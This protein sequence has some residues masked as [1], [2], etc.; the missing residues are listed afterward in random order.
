MDWGW[1]DVRLFLKYLK[2][3][4]IISYMLV[5]WFVVDKVDLVLFGYKLSLEYWFGRFE[6]FCEVLDEVSFKC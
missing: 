3:C 4:L 1:V 5:V 6:V 2:I